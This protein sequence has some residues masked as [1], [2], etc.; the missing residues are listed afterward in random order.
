MVLSAKA[1]TTDPYWAT[2]RAINFN[3][4]AHTEFYNGIQKDTSGGM[5]KFDL[6]PT[7]GMGMD[8]SLPYESFR[9]LPEIN[10]VLPQFNDN[11]KIMKN[12]FM[13]R[14]DAGYRPRDWLQLRLGTSLMLLNQQGR[15]GSTTMNNG[16]STSTFYYPDE[17]RSSW[18]N[19]FDVGVETIWENW[20]LRLQ[21]YTYSLFEEK[22][23]QLSYTLFITYY[24]E[25]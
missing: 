3:L 22:K 15:G 25:K 13:F 14:I 18:N 17:N 19:T 2:L 8:F 11:S 4:G 9:L 5:R 1:K 12:T 20:A 24:W 7:I 6:A 10:W 21:T 23:R 16:T